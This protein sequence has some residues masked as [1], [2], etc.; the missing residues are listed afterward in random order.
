MKVCFVT[1]NFP[2]YVGDS[3]GTFIWEAAHAIAKQG[4]QVRVIA[5][6]WP[7]YPVREWM[8]DLEIIRPQYWWPER[9]EIL[10]NAGGG[11]PVMWKKSP[12]ARL[13]MVIFVLVQS[14]T[15]V[16][17]S[18]GFD[19]IHAQWS[20]SAGIALLSR[21][22]WRIP[23]IVT[24]H[25]SD[26]FQ[27]TKNKMIL[28]V[29][30][31]ILHKC[32]RVIVVSKALKNYIFEKM[33]TSI[34]IT[35]IPDGINTRKW[36]PLNNKRGE[37]ILYVGALTKNKGIEYLIKAMPEIICRYPSFRLVIVGEGPERMHLE[38]MVIEVGLNKTAVTFTGPLPPDRVRQRM[39]QAKLFVLPSKSEGL[40]VVLLEALACGT[41][42]VAS[43]VGGIVDVISNEV[44]YLVPPSEPSA[45]SKAICLM[46]DHELQW[47]QMSQ[48]ARDRSRNYDWEKISL[49]M[50]RVYQQAL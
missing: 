22:M 19:V 31:Y 40:G 38:E 30:N 21:I 20:L 9:K 33:T 41:P 32:N 5:Q 2:R 16:R 23:I 12:L 46:L 47:Q 50:I 43:K 36:H 27:A 3:E 39:Q 18:Y 13:Q 11:I 37:F 8:G 24:L 4:H 10:R 48:S 7:G 14:L 42:V 26:I 25:G 35:V 1:T 28:H 45:L 6:H 44:G 29:T 15:V 34:D 49:H 17:F